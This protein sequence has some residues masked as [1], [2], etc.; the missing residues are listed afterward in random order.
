MLLLCLISHIICKSAN[1]ALGLIPRLEYFRE[2]KK[3][4]PCTART[5]LRLSENLLNRQFRVKK[6]NEK[7]FTEVAEERKLCLSAIPGFCDRCI[8]VSTHNFLVYKTFC[9]AV[10]VDPCVSPLS[11]NDIGPMD[12]VWG[13]SETRA[14]IGRRFTGRNSSRRYCSTRRAQPGCPY[15]I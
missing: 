15:A 3:K 2:H 6:A 11:R 9:K 5:F 14:L 8:R 13:H 4:S 10:K 1:N 12:G 7:W